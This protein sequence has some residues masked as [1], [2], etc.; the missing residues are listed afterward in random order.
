[1]SLDK[2]PLM[3]RFS[4]TS[5]TPTA[6]EIAELLLYAHIDR[7]PSGDGTLMTEPLLVVRGNHH[8]DFGVFDRAGKRVGSAMRSGE[9]SPGR[10]CTDEFLDAEGRCVIRVETVGSSAG[11]GRTKWVYELSGPQVPDVTK[12]SRVSR[13][14]PKA[15]ITQGSRAIG[16]LKPAKSFAGLVVEDEPGHPVARV[17]IAGAR[18]WKKFTDVV[19]EAEDGA[20]EELRKAALAATVIMDRETRSERRLRC[21]F[22]WPTRL[23]AG[24]GSARSGRAGAR[25]PM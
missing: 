8:G 11:R 23:L 22:R 24:G 6:Y 3:S 19:V 12:L 14:A 5:E 15:S 4:R 2:V 20:P 21:C 25:R 18:E 16:M 1:M 7:R 17:Y 10:L 13:W 9:R